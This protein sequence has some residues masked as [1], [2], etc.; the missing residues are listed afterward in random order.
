MSSFD[1][2]LTGNTEGTEGGLWVEEEEDEEER[3]GER[4]R[5]R[6]RERLTNI[7]YWKATPTHT[8]T[9]RKSTRLNSSH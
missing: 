2:K 6:E 7:T 4:K 8:A 3:W 1:L 9:D 5:G